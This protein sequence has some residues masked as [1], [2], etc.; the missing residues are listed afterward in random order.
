[1]DIDLKLMFKKMKYLFS[2][3]NYFNNFLYDWYS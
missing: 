3:S 2:F 1:M